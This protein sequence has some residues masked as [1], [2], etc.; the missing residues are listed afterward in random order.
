MSETVPPIPQEVLYYNS[1]SQI[2]GNTALTLDTR[3]N[4]TRLDTGN[5]LVGNRS[6]L[7]GDVGIRTATPR[8]ALEVTGNTIITSKG[9]SSQ[10]TNEFGLNG[11]YDSL[12]LVSPVGLGLNGTTS[13]FFGLNSLIYYPVARIV[14]ADNG[15]YS[16]SLAFQ[17]GNGQQLY[18]QMRLTMD[19]IISGNAAFLYK[20]Q[21]LDQTI[22][23]I[24]LDFSSIANSTSIIDVYVT[25]QET[26][27]SIVHMVKF[28]LFLG[29]DIFIT[30]I[31][32]QSSGAAPIISIKSMKVI[33]S[34][35]LVGYSAGISY[36]ATVNYMIY[37]PAAVLFPSIV[38]MT[39]DVGV[40]SV[41][42]K[43]SN[44][45]VTILSDT[46]ILLNWD[47]VSSGGSVITG[48]S[49]KETGLTKSVDNSG[50][51]ISDA[52]YLITLS[53]VII[54]TQIT[55]IGLTRGVTYVFTIQAKN[56]VG[57]SEE[58]LAISATPAV[59]P[60]AP[61]N[62]VATGGNALANITWLASSDNGG[63]DITSYTITSTPGNNRL[64]VGNVTNARFSG[65]TN[66]TPYTFTVLAINSIGSSVQSTSSNSVTPLSAPSAP[67]ITTVTPGVGSITI[68]WSEPDD[69]GTPITGYTVGDAIG[70]SVSSSVTIDGSGNISSGLVADPTNT[71]IIT[72]ASLISARK[73]TITGLTPGSL[74]SFRVSATNIVGT[75][76]DSTA[77]SETS[78]LGVPGAPTITNAAAGARSAVITWTAPASDGGSPIT[79]YTITSTPGNI[80]ATSST[81]TPTTVSGLSD[82]TSYTFVIKATNSAGDS[83][84]SDPSSSI[85][86]FNLPGVPTG[87]T[88]TSSTGAISLT[89]V[90][91]TNTGGTP[92][93][94][95]NI[96]DASGNIYNS[97]T[98]AFVSDTGSIT[99]TSNLS[100]N[101]TGL[102]DGS[103]YAFS[104]KAVNL[105]G[106][107]SAV[108]F[109]SITLGLPTAPLN[110]SGV[111]ANTQITFSWQ[112]PTSNGGSP[113]TGYKIADS[114]DAIVYDGTGNTAITTTITGLTNGTSYIYKISALNSRGASSYS[115]PITI[116]A[117]LPA[118]PTGF[119]AV[120]GDKSVTLSWSASSGNGSSIVGYR[121]F[122][123]SGVLYEADGT[124]VFT[125]AGP[126]YNSSSALVVDTS[127][128]YS[129]TSGL[130]ITLSSNFNNGV[131]Y[132]FAVYGANTYGQSSLP[133]FVS[134]TPGLPDTPSNLTASTGNGLV[135][136]S[137]TAPSS[138]PTPSSYLISYP[139]TTVTT[140]STN[141]V[142]NNLTNGSP[143]TFKVNSVNANGN[144][145]NY[146]SISATPFT[147]P[148]V[149]VNI[150]LSS[151]DTTGTISWQ[152][153]ISDGG[154]SILGYKIYD[155][156]GSIYDT[157]GNI[158]ADT[159]SIY[160]TNPS[161]F[162][163]TISG[164]TV[165]QT[166]TFNL[167]A[168][169]AAGNSLGSVLTIKTG[170]PG[171]PINLTA[172]PGDTSVV[173]TWTAPTTGTPT[174]YRIE[175]SGTSETTASNVLTKTITGL[176][177]TRQYTF[178]V[179]ATTSNGDS[180]VPAIINATPGLPYAPTGLN[181][182]VGTGS[183]TLS[184][185]APSVTGGSAITGY[186]VG[187]TIGSGTSV[188]DIPNITTTNAIISGL[189]SATSH[190]FTIKTKN[191]NGNSLSSASITLI[192]A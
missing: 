35:I 172:I 67:T 40:V 83:L 161:T 94:G 173:L 122:L 84:D 137:W 41:P 191:A 154:S 113:I 3:Y 182:Y 129:T 76:D 22:Y 78:T 14:A 46:S 8:G 175:Y 30:D 117:G 72:N 141:A 60:V 4:G 121:V 162:T 10:N 20:K 91:P 144:S 100:I 63:S 49:I 164:L 184:W 77:S 70:N 81:V 149:P 51:L 90:A 155:S 85:T 125:P 33:G 158:V 169:N 32:I 153:P 73:I 31:S 131:Q 24:A 38:L 135:S 188:T 101:I 126:L 106:L 157:S 156:S 29:V 115:A 88:A 68:E 134:V 37:G 138:G 13:I 180:L 124:T 150:L 166:Y 179:F 57:F 74:Y 80:T 86:T 104:I 120:A 52:T 23:N 28:T 19:G 178:S 152:A 44:L 11:N 136:L 118:T 102:T 168:S 187:Y 190:T 146:V 47:S 42:G 65:L 25:F 128:V 27:A 39:N 1:S 56:S 143:Y 127:T 54:D 98:N 108:S 114:T 18:Q 43:P 21:L 92:I 142:I 132:T 151:T 87:L 192:P 50:N 147:T 96:Y 185:T 139:S 103:T 163:Y 9:S 109:A 61:T 110:F 69:G 34:K 189:T 16:G 112:V 130:T 186:Q 2:A 71:Q 55:I 174:G 59:V 95:Y 89:W 181:G 99:T 79:L 26:T 62:I 116:I 48:Y 53:A 36:N 145:V 167:K 171:T 12:S 17:I 183:V 105:A 148:G 7:G 133:T 97:S 5:L 58:S 119:S 107:S 160:T 15:N 93:T 176:V 75:S 170:V 159:G 45:S 66:G 111:S 82:N 165:N 123:S 6:L 140:N 177:N 64:T